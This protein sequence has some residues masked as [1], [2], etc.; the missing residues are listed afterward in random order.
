MIKALQVSVVIILTS[1]FLFPFFFSFL[2]SVNT[3]M[4]LAV[5]GLI[6]FS[7]DCI[8]GYTQPFNKSLA[9]ISSWALGVSFC[10]FLSMTLNGTPDNSYLGYIVSMAVWLFAAYFCVSLMRLTHGKVTVEI[11]ACYLVGVALL[12]CTLALLINHF[13]F[14]KNLVDASIT[15]EKYMGVGVKGRLYGIGCALDVGGGRLGAILIL[16]AYLILLAMKRQSRWNFVALLGVFI[17]ILVIGNM[18]GRT[19]SVGG[20]LA[21]AYLAW[22]IVKSPNYRSVSFG[23]FLPL[24]ILV[25]GCGIL[26]CVGLYQVS[27]EA[28]KLLR[29]GFEGFFNYFEYGKFETSSTNMLSEGMIF[30]DN[31]WTW[32]FGDGYM[33]SGLNDPYYTGPS[34][35][36]FYMNTDAGYSRFIFYFGLTGLS[37]FILFFVAVCKECMARIKD[38]KL[39]FFVLLTMNLCVWVKVSTDLFLV[40][41]PFLCLNTQDIRCEMNNETSKEV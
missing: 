33:A 22:S 19:A 9:K 32:I 25:I 23:S 13:P 26:L 8:N 1:L 24:T 4:F 36:G 3:K 27:P 5:L 30:P 11:I 14:I 39:L 16:V 34:D 2:P 15:G 20:A 37:V 7:F 41:A 29:F 18:I 10:S 12:Q 38:H 21:L 28:Q 17:Y 40:F 31:L 6:A 35:Y